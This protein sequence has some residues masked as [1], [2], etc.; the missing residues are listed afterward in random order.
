MLHV[1]ARRPQ[2]VQ[3]GGWKPPLGFRQAEPTFDITVRS[4]QPHC[5]VVL[6]VWFA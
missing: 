1:V 2:D 6:N 4:R 5:P 3:R